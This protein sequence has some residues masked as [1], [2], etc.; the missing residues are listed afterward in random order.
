MGTEKHLSDAFLAGLAELTLQEV[1]EIEKTSKTSASIYAAFEDR[2]RRF[3][4]Y[5]HAFETESTS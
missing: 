2:V 5:P 1:L 4:A 3:L